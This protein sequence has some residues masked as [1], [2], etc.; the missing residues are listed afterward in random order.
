MGISM[1]QGQEERALKELEKAANQ[2]TWV[3]FQNVHLMQSWLK[4]F[5][6]KLDEIQHAA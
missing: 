4:P 2:G 3:M 6:R 1:G 5:E